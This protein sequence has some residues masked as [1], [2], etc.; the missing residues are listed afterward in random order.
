M[1]CPSDLA[2]PLTALN[3]RVE[4]ATAKG[5]PADSH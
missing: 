3:A 2:P 5:K 4:I 1:V